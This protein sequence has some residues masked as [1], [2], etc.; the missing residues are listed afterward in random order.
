MTTTG[1]RM[2]ISALRPAPL[3]LVYLAFP[4]TIGA[5]YIDYNVVDKVVVP[6]EHREF[7]TEKMFY[8]PHCYQ[9]N[10]FREL[11]GDLLNTSKDHGLCVF[12]YY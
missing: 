10:S 7:Y 2:G 11:Y 9:T 5:N 8:M 6:P 1:A 3:Q 4:G 12:F